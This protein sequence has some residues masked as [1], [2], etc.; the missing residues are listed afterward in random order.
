MIGIAALTLVSAVLV[1]AA[2]R[3]RRRR[4]SDDLSIAPLPAGLK[5][6]AS[7]VGTLSSFGMGLRVP[8]HRN[9]RRRT[10]ALIGVR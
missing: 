3:V 5:H 4:R 10:G 7:H 2:V 1:I 6:L 8:A 9:G